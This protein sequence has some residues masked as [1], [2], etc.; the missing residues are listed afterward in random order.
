MGIKANTFP[1]STSR[2]QTQTLTIANLVS[3]SNVSVNTGSV[4]YTVSG[5]TIT[6]T[7]SGGAVTRTVQTGGSAPTSTYK[8]GSATNAG[9][10]REQQGCSTAQ[11]AALSGLPSSISYNDGTYSGS[12]SKIGS[13]A[14]SCSL[15]NGIYQSIATGSYGG[16]VWTSDTRT[17][18]N[19]YQYTVTVTYVDNRNP[20]LTLS[21]PADNQTL[22][23]GSSYL[24]GGHASDADS[25]NVMTVMY[26]INNGTAR[27]LASG[28]SDGSSSLTFDKALKYSNKRLWDGSTNVSGDELAENIDHILTVWSEDNQGGKSAE[29]NRKFR[30]IWNRPPTI[31]GEDDD[32]G[33][34]LVPP[35]IEYSAV[36]PEGNTFTFTEYLNGQEIRSFAGVGNK[37]Y[38]VQISHDAWIRLDLDVQH[39]IKI[40]ATD[41]AGLSSE[42]IYTFTRTETHIE[43]MLNF[44]SPDV[45]GHFILDGMPQ[46]VLVTLERYIPEGAVIESVKVCNNALDASPTW[47]DAT[48]AVK[49]NRGFVFTNTNKTDENWAINIWVIIAKGTAT[50]RVRLN[51]YG[52]AFD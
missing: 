1:E 24:I 43:F 16:T 4:S 50:E 25:G 8:T 46:R 36:D 41:S 35:T 9:Y 2:T 3:V 34:L 13:S 38:T 17:Y 5:T 19:Y 45:Q 33:T 31:S 48:S 23:E 14:S 7:L 37:E 28:V 40:K 26:K 10:V 47:E 32:L 20:A 49:S 30:V 27:A 42:R 29:T 22:A 44:D 12:L 15:N 21:A 51:G 52:G 18:A 6:F 11:T 39:Q